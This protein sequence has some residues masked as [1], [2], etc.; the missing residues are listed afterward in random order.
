MWGVYS[1]LWDTC[2]YLFIVAKIAK[3]LYYEIIYFLMH[4]FVKE[5]FLF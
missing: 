4:I 5:M 3:H 2:M 1:L